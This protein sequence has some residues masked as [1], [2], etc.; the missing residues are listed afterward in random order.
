MDDY[1]ELTQSPNGLV[2]AD[3]IKFYDPTPNFI[4]QIL[5]PKATPAIVPQGIATSVLLTVRIS[6]LND[7]INTVMID[8][9]KIGGPTQQSMYDDGTN[10]DVTSGDDVFSFQTTVPDTVISNIYYLLVKAKD[11][12]DLSS[13][14]HI[15]LKV[16]S[17]CEMIMDNPEVSLVGNRY[18]HWRLWG[19][20]DLFPFNSYGGYG[21]ACLESLPK[22]GG[23]GSATATWTPDLSCTGLYNVYAW[24]PSTENAATNAPYTIYHNGGS[25]QVIVNQT[26]NGDQWN[27]LG[28]YYFD[29]GTSGYVVLSNKANNRV[30][31]D[32]IKWE[33]VP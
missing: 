7:N 30:Y 2:I 1:V 19:S 18:N 5:D 3:A 16:L 21:F 20:Q 22:S 26:V 31:A 6:D 4:P 13:Y 27:L 28:T 9:S 33:K 12:T 10:G 32:A 11:L 8:L 17:P 24:W 14:K 23:D 25:S 29:S 15:M